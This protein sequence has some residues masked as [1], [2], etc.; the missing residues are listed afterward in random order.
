MELP[1]QDVKG[2]A[3]HG[4]RDVGMESAAREHVEMRY[5]GTDADELDM[6]VL[7]RTQETRRIF[8]A[9]SMLGYASL[10]TALRAA[11]ADGTIASARR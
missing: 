11:M 8:T 2:D 4:A 1:E 10:S 5:R 6:K 7:G 3:V 9:V